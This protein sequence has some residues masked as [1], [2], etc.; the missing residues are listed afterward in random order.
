MPNRKLVHIGEEPK[1]PTIAQFFGEMADR[2]HEEIERLKAEA[3]R[4]S[5]R[6]KPTKAKKSSGKKVEPYPWLL[7]PVRK[8]KAARK[9]AAAKKGAPKEKQPAKRTK[10]KAKK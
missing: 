9:K 7:H 2:Q 8:V 5:K 4:S 1:L 10:S 6:T 3:A